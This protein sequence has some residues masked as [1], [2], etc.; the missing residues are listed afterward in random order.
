MSSGKGSEMYNQED[1]IEAAANSTA[2]KP[3]LLHFR[4]TKGDLAGGITTVYCSRSTEDPRPF[5]YI[6]RSD[7]PTSSSW[8]EKHPCEWGVGLEGLT[9]II[10]PQLIDCAAV[11][12]TPTELGAWKKFFYEN[13]NEKL[14]LGEALEFVTYLD[15]MEIVNLGAKMAKSPLFKTVDVYSVPEEVDEPK[16]IKELARLVKKNRK[17]FSALFGIYRKLGYSFSIQKMESH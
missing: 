3:Q 13:D 10:F 9:Q 11:R 7:W 14:L 8:E 5:F 16:E 4:N 12:V 15:F 2:K 1:F 17:Q 6:A